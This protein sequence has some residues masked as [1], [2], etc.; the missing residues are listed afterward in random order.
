MRNRLREF[1]IASS[2]QSRSEMRNN[3]IKNESKNP[4]KEYSVGGYTFKTKEGAQA[5]KDELAAIKY[6]SSKTDS[7]NAK[8][9]Y[10][11]YHDIIDKKLF[12]TL[13]GMNYL[14]ELQQ[15]LYLS[16]DVPN[17]KIRP[18]P[19]NN[20]TK[21]MMEGRRELTEHK[22][23]IRKLTKERNHYKDNFVISVIVNVVLVVVIA[24]MIYITLHSSNANVIN[25]EVN[26]QDKYASWQEEL[27]SQEESLNARERALNQQK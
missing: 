14:K 26:L 1:L 22:S 17:E 19:I 7:T 13:I 2:R 6:M 20:E 5:A 8:Q 25:Y 4:S 27:Q 15:F 23:E 21:E 9:V 3:M 12:N 16:P 10:I 11:L 18:I 24:A